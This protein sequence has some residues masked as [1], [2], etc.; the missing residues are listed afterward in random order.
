MVRVRVRVRVRVQGACDG[1]GPS[2]Y[3]QANHA[4]LIRMP[5]AMHTRLKT[6]TRD[7]DAMPC[8]HG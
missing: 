2:Y 7:Q 8:M 6:C 1:T 4:R 3:R 5:E